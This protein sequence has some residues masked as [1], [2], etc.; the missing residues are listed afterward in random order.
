LDGYGMPTVL[1]NQWV[2]TAHHTRCSTPQTVC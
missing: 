2:C 1:W